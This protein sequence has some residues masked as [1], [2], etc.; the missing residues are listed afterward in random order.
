MPARIGYKFG[1]SSHDPVRI[2]DP[3]T[4]QKAQQKGKRIPF[5]K[6][7]YARALLDAGMSTHKVGRVVGVSSNTASVIRRDPDLSPEIVQFFKNSI[8]GRFYKHAH[9][10]LDFITDEKLEKMDA[11]R[12]TLTAKIGLDAARLAEGLPTQTV[13]VKSVAINLQG[14][15]KS[16]QKKREALLSALGGAVSELP[17]PTTIVKED[18][19]KSQV[20]KL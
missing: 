4:H 1:M 19:N 11:Y 17:T 6:R 12:L 5:A 10:S 13:H 7:L 16:L 3:L 15:L 9:K 2:N 18:V 20:N 8:A 14:E